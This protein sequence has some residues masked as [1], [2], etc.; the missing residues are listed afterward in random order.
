MPVANRFRSRSSLDLSP[1]TFSARTVRVATLEVN[2]KVF[3]RH[4]ADVATGFARSRQG[5]QRFG[6]AGKTRRAAITGKLKRIGENGKMRARHEKPAVESHV[7]CRGRARS[8]RSHYFQLEQPI[9]SKPP[10]RAMSAAFA[11]SLYGNTRNRVRLRTR[12]KIGRRM[13]TIE[14]HHAE[15]VGSVLAWRRGSSSTSS[16]SSTSTSTSTSKITSMGLCAK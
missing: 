6:K 15:T 14:V 7:Q 12:R 9:R 2:R 3:L 5:C 10:A 16:S 11:A 4:R 13:T 1:K 8:I